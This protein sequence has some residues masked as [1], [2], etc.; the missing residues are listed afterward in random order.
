METKE[1]PEA[2]RQALE[3]AGIDLLTAICVDKQGKIHRVKGQD[4]NERPTQFPVQTTAIQDITAVSM[5][6]HK[7]SDCWTIIIGGIPHTFC[8]P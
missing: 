8:W 5:V 6:R 3:E 4:V 7:G 2:A 1:L